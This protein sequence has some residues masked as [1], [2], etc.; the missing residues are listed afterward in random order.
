MVEA[1]SALAGSPAVGDALDPAPQVGPM[2]TAAHRDRVEGYIA[3]GRAARSSPL[4]PG[5]A[6]CVD[7]GPGRLRG[8]RPRRG[9]RPRRHASRGLRRR[10]APAAREGRPWRHDLLAPTAARRRPT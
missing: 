4:R 9:D 2:T 6:A 1:L 8:V 7:D 5:L 10:R 3:K